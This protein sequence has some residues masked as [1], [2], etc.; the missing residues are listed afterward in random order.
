MKCLYYLLINL[1]C[2]GAV[3]AQSNYKVS[4]IPS[5]LRSGQDAV[6][7]N[8][9]GRFEV[10]AKDKCQYMER[11]VVTI[12]NA[13]AKGHAELSLNY[14]EDIKIKKI[15][16]FLYDKHGNLVEKYK[17]KDFIDHSAIDN[18]TLYDDS[19]VKYLNLKKESYPYTVEFNYELV[20]NYLFHTPDWYVFNDYD[21]SV[22]KSSFELVYPVALPLRYKTIN[23]EVAP[24]ES[25]ANGNSKLSW[26]FSKL[27]GRSREPFS[28]GLLDFTPIIRTSPT[29]F[30]FDG[31]EGDISTWDGFAFFQNELDRDLGAVPEA[32]ARDIKDLV[33]ELPSEKAKIRAIYKYMQSNTRYISVQLG[34]GGFKPFPPA[35]VAENGYGDCKALTYYTKSLLA[36]ANIESQY[37][38]ISAGDNP[39][40]VDLAF[41]NN[42]FN[43]VILCVPNAGDTVWL[44]CT[45]QKIPA[46]YLG[47]FTADRYALLLHN[48]GSSKLVKTPK[49]LGNKNRIIMTASLDLA[50]DNNAKVQLD[51][52]M[53]GV[54][55]EYNG[56]SYYINRSQVDQ[57]KW[58]NRF[59]SLPD[60]R[61]NDFAFVQH[62]D[63]IPKI[64]V[65]AQFD[66][67]SYATAVSDRLLFNM[68][69]LIPIGSRLKAD[70]NRE[71]P[72]NL[73]V[74][75]SFELITNV[76]FPAYYTIEKMPAGKSLETEFGT[77]NIT[78]KENENGISCSRML[79]FK[80]GTYGKDK[81]N[82]FV[83]FMNEIKALE[84]QRVMLRKSS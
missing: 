59:I 62:D 46:G 9:Y 14:S 64:D 25:F 32:V 57:E 1:L 20:Y 41:P 10:L 84:S 45:D 50:A 54:G 6:I 2:C 68:S 55:V 82:D 61:V 8:E 72:I 16:A 3:F 71:S 42:N 33:S 11:R 47:S 52:N 60:F 4:A 66:V 75:S 21:L 67:R 26:T 7:R 53:L 18:G 36:I 5:E 37:S 17:E 40:A 73:R 48:N 65:M 74:N 63:S 31:Y 27:K 83:H 58:I 76:Q 43:H 56:L 28:N 19:R 12:L 13:K 38:L 30:M 49:Y 34:I 35:Y 39:R 29:K 81:Y 22:E 24:I 44:E 23:T 15:E 69:S 78:Y 80:N 51:L 79:Y 70:D 77:Y